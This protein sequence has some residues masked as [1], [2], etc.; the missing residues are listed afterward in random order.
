MESGEADLRSEA[1]SSNGRRQAPRGA[2]DR[3]RRRVM[4]SYSQI[5]AGRCA[6][7]FIRSAVVA[8]CGYG[9]VQDVRVWR[10]SAAER[11]E[12]A[13][14]GGAGSEKEPLV[15]VLVLVLVLDRRN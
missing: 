1:G 6:Q 14:W 13:S 4:R 2:G 3:L 5:F 10:R 8:A 11:A 15:L 9:M 12:G 7:H